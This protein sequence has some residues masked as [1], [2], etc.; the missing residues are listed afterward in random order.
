MRKIALFIATCML[1][2]NISYAFVVR[3][4]D[5][6]SEKVIP[7]SFTS[8]NNN[9]EE[10]LDIDGLDNVKIEKVYTDNGNVNAYID[11]DYITLELSGGEKTNSL[12]KVTKTDT[13][14]IEDNPL[15][16]ERNRIIEIDN[17]RDIKEITGVF[18]DFE[19]ANINQKGNIEIKVNKQAD[20]IKGYDKNKKT[21]TKVNISIDEGNLDKLAESE[22]INLEH[23]IIGDIKVVSK[24]TSVV[25]DIITKDNSV[26]VVFNN[27]QPTLNETQVTSGYTYFWIDRDSDG[28]FRKYNPNSIYSTDK[29]K[30][31]GKGEYLDENEID[32]LGINLSN[33]NWT[34]YC[35]A[36]INGVRYIYLF[37]Q[38]NIEPNQIEGEILF[39]NFVEV[40]NQAFNTEKYT[41]YFSEEGVLYVPEGKLYSM[42]ELVKG[43]SGW[44][45][46]VPNH[47]WESKE[48]FF[49]ELTGKNETYVKHYKFFYGPEKKK[50]F[51]GFF[52]YPY[53]C[54]LEYEH[55]KPADLYSGQIAYTYTSTE[56]VRGYLYNGWVKISYTEKKSVNDYPPTSPYNIKY[57]ESSNVIS[58]H[59]G[60]DDYT[61]ENKLSYQMQMYS[62]SWGDTVNI[63]LGK[64]SIEYRIIHDDYDIR[65]RTVDELGQVSD[66]AKLSDNVI[67]LAGN[68]NPSIIKAGET[69][70]INAHT[71][72]LAKIDHVTAK[73]EELGINN[74]LYKISENVPDYLE[75]SYDIVADFL[76]EDE[77]LY[78]KNGR[79]AK[80]IDGEYW[81]HRLYAGEKYNNDTLE[82]EL[83][84]NIEI[85]PN[86]TIIFP[87]GN[88]LNSPKDIFIYNN[89]KLYLHRKNGIGILNKITG[90]KEWFVAFVTEEN[91][92]YINGDP[93]ITFSNQLI[94]NT[95]E[96]DEKGTPQFIK[97]EIGK[98]LGDRPIVI[99]WNTDVSGVTRFN[100]GFENKI[101]YSYKVDYNVLKKYIKN[102]EYEKFEKYIKK[103]IR[104][105]KGYSYPSN[106]FV[107]D[108]A[109]I[110]LDVI[111]NYTLED[112][113]WLGYKVAKNEYV[114][115]TYITNYNNNPKVR[116]TYRTLVLDE[117]ASDIAV[118]KYIN[119]IKTTNIPIINDDGESVF[120]DDVIE[121]NCEF[122]IENVKTNNNVLPGKYELKLT[123]TD[124]DG[125]SNT[126]LLPV[127]VEEDEKQMYPEE[128]ETIETLKQEIKDIL[129]GRFFYKNSKGYLEELKKGSKNSDSEGFICAG[130]TIGFNFIVDNAEFLEVDFVGD[131]SIKT[132]DSLSKIFLIEKPRENGKDVKNINEKYEKF[133]KRIYPVKTNENGESEFKYFYTIPYGTEQS[134]HSWSTLK[135]S[136]IEQIDKN[137]LFNKI[138]DPYKLKIKVNGEEENCYE[139]FFDVFERWD[140]VIN[141]DVSKYIINSE[142]KWEIRIDNDEK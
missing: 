104:T 20:G 21:K 61:S 63:E 32:Q 35:G 8:D 13:L 118:N 71:K 2:S 95:F 105:S 114:R 106:K 51:G 77:F 36:E 81:N 29:N 43:T 86:G 44:G 139:I 97:I 109:K 93:I 82:V 136:T 117:Y 138:K 115:D 64:N 78:I 124:V 62:G 47:D 130:E 19:S 92:K 27:G 125:N 53:N 39:K 1:Y 141:R 30:I 70:N 100:I 131:S 112:F 128:E 52:T 84:G 90:E 65:I 116:N 108:W 23:E 76:E 120:G 46:T 119:L 113:L 5:I 132:L 79:Y 67:D 68:V 40:E 57:D 33:S 37:N 121:Y 4:V 73:S 96:Y 26:K 110:V 38:D 11:E 3:D 133:P 7:F 123:A 66:W 72:S 12:K 87:S 75:I 49:N 127:I 25:E 98:E 34:D 88:Y 10:Y 140:T 89:K 99:R 142:S 22:W 134:I 28:T 42:G 126:I 94:I 69:I 107:V 9:L 14:E 31:S 18:G 80:T 17:D 122:L 83:P 85:T 45:E 6:K 74:E 111:P 59:H 41:V 91:R 129:V 58:W 103:Y 102:I 48:I 50:A 135:S 137:K 60:T 15:T 101:I 16:D 55:F 54:I 24:D 56:Y